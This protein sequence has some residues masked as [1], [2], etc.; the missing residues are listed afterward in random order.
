MTFLGSYLKVQ[1]V[2]EGRAQPA[3]TVR[4]IHLADA[5]MVFIPL[6]LAGEA[7]A[8][9]AAMVGDNRANP[10]LLVVPQPR[11]RDQRFAFLAELA[12]VL[13]PYIQG[14]ASRIEYPHERC[15]DAPQILLPTPGGVAFTRLLGR[16]SRFRRTSGPHA[17]PPLVPQLGRWLT[18]LHERSEFAD[19]AMLLAMTDVLTEY[20]VTGQSN[21]EDANL[22]AVMAWIDPPPDMRGDEAAL[23]AED[24]LRSPPA[25]PDTDPGFDREVLQ[26]L[27]DSYESTGDA[28]PLRYALHEQLQPTWHLMWQAVDLLRALPEA[29]SVP[30]RWERDR[31]AV[32]RESIR[33]AQGGFPQG[34]WDNPQA[35]ARRLAMLES[36]QQSYE[37]SKAFDDP[38]VMADYR[39]EGVAFEGEVVEVE[40][41]RKIVPPGKTRRVNRPLVT[42]RTDDPVRLTPGAKLLSPQRPKQSCRLVSA[43]AGVMVIQINSGMT[44]G[45]TIPGVGEIVCYTELDPGGGHRPR[46]PSLDQTP[47]THG[48]PPQEYVPTDEDAQEV[49]S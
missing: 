46:L 7:A 17:V 15:F 18:F 2:H 34:R 28:G 1:A 10:R 26:P 30:G 21:A 31:A 3:A 40:A 13:V 36:A 44:K 49:W 38:L 22:A 48:G 19:S 33:I 5:P 41:D 39:A 47:W 32:A 29:A 35:A 43:D 6:R 4:H 8:P 23:L 12:A 11:N 25:G 45:A 16:S 37:A 27:I 24:P 42:V 9:L 20:W 14:F